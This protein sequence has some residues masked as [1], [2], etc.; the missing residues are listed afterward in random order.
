MNTI[1]VH[2]CAHTLWQGDADAKIDMIPEVRDGQAV[3]KTSL[4]DI[5]EALSSNPDDVK[6]GDD[7]KKKEV[8][9][10]EDTK[11]ESSVA[12]INKIPFPTTTAEKRKPAEEAEKAKH[13]EEERPRIPAVDISQFLP[14]EVKD[15]PEEE[16]NEVGSLLETFAKK[17]R[18]LPT[19][20][21]P[22]LKKRKVE[23]E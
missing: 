2:V 3:I 14:V 20:K 5:L 22:K 1:S 19:P 9:Q 23:N 11:K 16:G 7:K 18:S 8:K 6:K 13:V 12:A 4:I 15:E 17:K 21:Q 10:R